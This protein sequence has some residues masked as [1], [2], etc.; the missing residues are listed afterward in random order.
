[1]P[2]TPRFAS[3]CLG[4]C[5]AVCLGA[6]SDLR[7][8]ASMPPA[9][10]DMAAV[11]PNRWYA[12][13]PHGGD[14]QALSD[15]WQSLGD[16]VLVTLIHAAEVVSPSLASAQ[17]NVVQS[18]SVR[19]Q[20][21]A[22]N[23][24]TLDAN[25]L[26]ERGV[27]SSTPLVSTLLQGSLDASW[28]IDLFGANRASANAAEARY[29]SARAQWHVA[30]VPVAAETATDYFGWQ[31]CQLQKGIAAQDAAS[32]QRSAELTHRSAQAG[33]T[34]PVNAALAD[35]ASQ[36]SQSQLT[37]QTRQC[38]GLL[39]ALVA[40]TG[41][42]EPDLR[43]QLSSAPPEPLQPQAL[44]VARIPAELLNQRPDVYAAQQLVAAASADLG[45][46]QARRYPRLTLSGS[47]GA[48]ELN[49]ASG[50]TDLSTW[51]IGPLALSLPIFDGGRQT[52][53]IA[54]AQ[55][56]YTE[57]TATY[58][59]AVRQAVREVEDALLALAA[60]S[61]QEQQARAAAQS[62]QIAMHASE[63]RFQA[64]TANQLDL[65]DARRS[66]LSA[67]H[68]LLQRGLDQRT[69]WIAL[70]RAVGG[71]WDARTTESTTPELP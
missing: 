59:G 7:G 46:A 16:P 23:R 38:E 34:A 40:L 66:L 54:S 4:L 14:L 1:M 45:A 8:P 3:V 37:Q 58:R 63:A 36:D 17:A 29:Q 55:A 18:R 35:A 50:S 24:P 42:A 60:A 28:E 20:A 62:Y 9:T 26:A 33:L 57:A 12:P 30:R 61:D 32:R 68:N 6:C 31:T 44:H 11:I 56:R 5:L 70:Y 65:Q 67:Q 53:N 71:G 64:G 47:I 15:W 27:T 39:K 43:L 52:A 48:L 10:A 21:Q 13:Q 49:N 41:L 51:A 22:A 2:F 19:T 69:A 25:A